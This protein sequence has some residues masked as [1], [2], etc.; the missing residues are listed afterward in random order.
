MR[1]C[2]TLLGVALLMPIWVVSVMDDAMAMAGIATKL[3][4]VLLVVN[5][6]NVETSCLR[7]QLS[8]LTLVVE[9]L[10]REAGGSS[11]GDARGSAPPPLKTDVVLRHSMV[12]EAS[13]AVRSEIETVDIHDKEEHQ[14]QL[15]HMDIC[16]CEN[17]HS[18]ASEAEVGEKN[19]R[20][21]VALN[22]ARTAV[23]EG[24]VPD[25]GVAL[26]CATKE[27]DQISTTKEDERIGVQIIKN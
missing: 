21:I 8:S 17:N 5:Y 10:T 22:V 7:T 20:V 6:R 2:C 19:D 26:L 11:M 12:A 3:D 9:K 14:I 18:G 16:I 23:E 13:V 15:L 27:L 25:G 24:I 4:R 1:L